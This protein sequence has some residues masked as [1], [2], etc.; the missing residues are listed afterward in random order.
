MHR[1]LALLLFAVAVSARAELPNVDR[2]GDPLPD[3]AVARLGSMRFT[4]SAALE[5][6]AFAA[7][8][9]TIVFFG[10][11][12]IVGRWDAVSGKELRR[13]QLRRS[14]LGGIIISCDGALLVTM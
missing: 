13:V 10:R 3:G 12:N 2:F 11:D 5:Q 1:H 4:H 7:D 14:S 8:G 9:K 6:F